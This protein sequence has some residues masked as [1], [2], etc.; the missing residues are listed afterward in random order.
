[1]ESHAVASQWS[2]YQQ[3]PRSSHREHSSRKEYSL[4]QATSGSFA[5]RHYGEG[6]LIVPLAALRD[7]IQPFPTFSEIFVEALH[8]LHTAV[9][10]PVGAQVD[11][12]EGVT[13]CA[14]SMGRSY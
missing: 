10:K 6:E 4:F 5:Q 9:H 12:Y 7:T 2:P 11:I 3:E 1:L 13:R 8:A 14:G